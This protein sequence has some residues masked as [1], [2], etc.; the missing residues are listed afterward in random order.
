MEDTKRVIAN[1]DSGI[2][3]LMDLPRMYNHFYKSPFDCTNIFEIHN[4]LRENNFDVY[5]F[6]DCVKNWIFNGENNSYRIDLA[7]VNLEES[8]EKF[9]SSLAAKPSPFDYE[10]FS[11]NVS[12]NFSKKPANKIVEN[13]KVFDELKRYKLEP[14]WLDKEKIQHPNSWADIYL[15]LITPK[16]L[17]ERNF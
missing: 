6:G 4:T 13:E 10:K 7:C 12:K 8:I 17:L 3:L 16:D 1:K 11:F 15:T 5:L 14:V 9:E 2:V